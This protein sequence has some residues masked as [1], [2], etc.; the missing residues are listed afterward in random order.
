GAGPPFPPVPEDTHHRPVS[1]ERSS[2]SKEEG[3]AFHG[4]ITTLPLEVGS[5]EARTP[6]GAPPPVEATRF[7]KDSG[8]RGGAE[9]LLSGAPRSHGFLPN[10]P[11]SPRRPRADRDP[12]RYRQQARHRGPCA[13]RPARPSPPL[14]PTRDRGRKSGTVPGKEE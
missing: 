6:P 1:E 10:R 12:A 3:A 7:G 11:V 14:L 9:S 5:V 2:A 8:F 4:R 13:V